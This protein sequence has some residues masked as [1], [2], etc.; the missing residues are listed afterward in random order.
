MPEQIVDQGGNVA[1]LRYTAAVAIRRL[2]NAGRGSFFI[3]VV[4]HESDVADVNRTI[5][6]CISGGG[7][8]GHELIARA[9]VILEGNQMTLRIRQKTIA[10]RIYIEGDV[11]VGKGV[12][13]AEHVYS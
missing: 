3:Q 8:P 10:L 1:Y 12:G 13:N 9:E 11:A 6:I 5:T 4:D 7:I 2:G